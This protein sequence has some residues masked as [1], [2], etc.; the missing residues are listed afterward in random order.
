MGHGNLPCFI[1]VFDKKGGGESVRRKV[2]SGK[3]DG[4]ESVHN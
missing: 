4:D 3:R 1:A 2:E